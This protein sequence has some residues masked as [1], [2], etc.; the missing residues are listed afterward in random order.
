MRNG[1]DILLNNLVKV[2]SNLSAFALEWK[3]KPALAFTHLQP[4]IL[5]TVGKCAA[6]W[7]LELY[8]DLANI[9]QVRDNL[10][11]R[12]AMGTVGSQASFIEIFHGDASKCDRLNE[13]LY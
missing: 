1:L 10:M 7:L 9:E 3:S 5:T 8:M 11:L 4:A 12:G 2:I 6:G 13:L